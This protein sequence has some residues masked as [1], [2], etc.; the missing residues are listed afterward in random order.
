MYLYK[1]GRVYWTEFEYAGARFQKST[2]CTNMRGARA[3]AN[4]IRVEVQNTLGP[5]GH[6]P[7]VRLSMLEALDIARVRAKGM[8][9]RETDIENLWAP[10]LRILGRGRDAQSLT[11]ADV[12]QYE[13]TRRS[14]KHRGEP[15]RGQTIR[16]EVQALR[17][18]L[19]LAEKDG[20]IYRSP[21]RW[22]HM[23]AVQSDPPSAAKSGKLWTADEIQLVFAAL[24]KK[25]VT[26]GVRDRLR[27]IQLTGLRMEELRRL[28]PSWVKDG[29]LCVPHAGSKTKQPRVVPL[30]NEALA[31]IKKYQGFDARSPNRALKL[32]SA[33]AGFT[34]VLTPRDLRTFFITHAGR[35]NLTAARDLAGHTNIAT[36]SR[37]LKSD[38]RS[39]MEAAQAAQD[40]AKVPTARSRQSKRGRQNV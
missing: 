19:T 25:A 12:V 23:D 37:Y 31:I 22:E 5:G 24:S 26:Y 8:T 35:N 1:R 13:L 34:A 4:E 6:R 36:T 11:R 16:R 30:S 14:E 39:L 28:S 10:L 38:A 7:G 18:G 15:I 9:R 32:A 40:A 27:L 3:R 33:R 17:R 20:L 29:V 2:G 21:I